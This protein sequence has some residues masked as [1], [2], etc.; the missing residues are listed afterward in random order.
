[1]ADDSPPLPSIRPRR[2]LARG[3]CLVLAVGLAWPWR[4]ESW[5][6]TSAVLPALSPLV[7]LGGAL[8][9]RSVGLLLLLALPILLLAWW[10]PRVLC[11]YVCPVGLLQ[12]GIARGR[13]R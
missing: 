9:S 1:M 11:N 6:W 3:V 7:A 13:G 12:E 8:A 2:L 4:G 10:I 5:P